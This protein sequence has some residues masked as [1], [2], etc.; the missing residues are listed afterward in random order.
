MKYKIIIGNVDVDLCK[1][2]NT[3]IWWNGWNNEFNRIVT[4]DYLYGKNNYKFM[5]RIISLSRMLKI[6][7]EI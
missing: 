5:T 6:L 2:N 4:F 7:N 3:M 1:N